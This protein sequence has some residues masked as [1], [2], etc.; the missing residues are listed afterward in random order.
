MSQN[1]VNNT[2]INQVTD[3]AI[4]ALVKAFKDGYS[5]ASKQVYQLPPDG[6]IRETARKVL[7]QERIDFSL[8]RTASCNSDL[9]LAESAREVGVFF[10]KRLCKN[11]GDCPLCP[12]GEFDYVGGEYFALGELDVYID[13]N[14]TALEA[15]LRE[16]A[17]SWYEA[18]FDDEYWKASREQAEYGHIDTTAGTGNN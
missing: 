1:I 10:N 14:E 6:E 2:E 7:E 15:G 16:C 4:D 8:R 5:Q 9:T 12:G 18:W 3:A 17:K 13:R 11:T